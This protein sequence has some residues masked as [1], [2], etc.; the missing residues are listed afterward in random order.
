M[1]IARALSNAVSGLTATARNTETV[2]ANIA[3]VSTPGYARREVAL[4]A[5]NLGGNSGGVRVDGISRIINATLL[6][7]AR[8]A[9]SAS[10]DAS[11]RLEF[12]SRMGELV[13]LPGD[14]KS[15]GSALTDFQVALQSA[16]SRPDDDLRLSAITDA[17]QRLAKRLN[18]ASVGVQEA[19]GSAD[20]AIASDV[21]SLNSNLER[22]AALNR[23]ITII[24]SEGADPSSLVDE[25]QAVIDR[26]ARIVPVQEIARDGGKVAL[27][28]TEGAVLLDGSLPARFE[29][30]SV[31]KMTPDLSVGTPPVMR[32][33]QNG[34][35]LTSGQMRLFAG[36]SLSANFAI[37]D[38]LGPQLQRELDALAFDLHAR[39][40][41]P[42]ADPSLTMTDAGLFT[43]AGSRATDANI[44]G[45]ALR[46][47]VNTSVLPG[48]GGELWRL[49]SGL[50]AAAPGPVGDSSLLL[51]MAG[52]L[53]EARP[54]QLGSG[55]EGNGSLSGR[56]AS[57]E[58]RVAAR[59]VSAEAETAISNSRT[60][61]I[62]SRLMAD[63][64]DS[65]A[66]MQRLLQYEQAY[67]A[68][69][70]V[71]QALDE[72]MQSILRL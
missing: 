14:A 63:G 46:L 18:S 54:G 10:A 33:V 30:A 17:A 49:R 38:E 23:R 37:R 52:A 40:A 65:D 6:S 13:G 61:T 8:L 32:L 3:N 9:S 16:A 48:S 34:Q 67:A 15:L 58:A 36:G 62:S 66:E 47:A 60:E 50:G 70:R 20:Q 24:E 39:L 4:S 1:S 45:L 57:I 35:E 41:D 42:T 64:V 55:F 31:G 2:A 7:E 53:D 59:R 11:G 21:A 25:R 56:F 12:L 43:D 19:R 69:A 5:Q 72:M 28:S 26:I 44:D 71:I 22:V 51:A 27:F 29:F 68:N